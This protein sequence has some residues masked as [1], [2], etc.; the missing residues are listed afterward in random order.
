MKN[1]FYL[2]LLASA[3]LGLTAFTLHLGAATTVDSVITSGLFEPYAVAVDPNGDLYISDGANH[4]ILK[5]PA[6][7]TSASVLAGQT[8]VAGANVGR[9]R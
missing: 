6:G 9:A 4:R 2:R 1:L 5:V 3:A 8:G 7:L